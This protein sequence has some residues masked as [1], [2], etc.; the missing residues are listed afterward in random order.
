MP[1]TGPEVA[2]TDFHQNSISS[3]NGPPSAILHR[4]LF[5]P[6]ATLGLQG[7]VGNQAVQR[8]IQN[9]SIQRK[10]TLYDEKGRPYPGKREKDATAEEI[11]DWVFSHIGRKAHE[12]LSVHKEML[13]KL[14]EDKGVDL[15]LSAASRGAEASYKSFLE[16]FEKFREAAEA[17][18]KQGTGQES[19]VRPAKGEKGDKGEYGADIELQP[20]I[21]AVSEGGIT[22][23][24]LALEGALN[25]FVQRAKDGSKAEIKSKF[26]KPL[27]PQL[28]LLLS[29]LTIGLSNFQAEDYPNLLQVIRLQSTFEYDLLTGV[30]RDIDRCLVDL[31][32]AVKIAQVAMADE[33]VGDPE[34]K[35]SLVYDLLADVIQ[36]S[37]HQFLELLFGGEIKRGRH[38]KSS[39]SS[40]ATWPQLESALG[41]LV[42]C[43]PLIRQ[44]HP[45]AVTHFALYDW[46]VRPLIVKILQG[47]VRRFKVESTL[48]CV[49][50]LDPLVPQLSRFA[51]RG[52]ISKVAFDS[53]HSK[54]T[55]FVMGA[56]IYSAKG[57]IRI[58]ET[59]CGLLM[60]DD[61]LTCIGYEAIANDSVPAD[62]ILTGH[63]PQSNE[64]LIV[65]I[66]NIPEGVRREGK[67]YEYLCQRYT[68]KMSTVGKLLESLPHEYKL[69]LMAPIGTK[70][71]ENDIAM[72]EK[73]DRF[74]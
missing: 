30:S 70:L 23:V 24:A 45:I 2:V 41:E 57:Q 14:C 51:E 18:K 33:D 52:R 1:S 17:E 39:T 69:V 49:I 37:R 15:K 11:L 36:M 5:S 71:L 56:T 62:L 25:P 35:A 48:D 67:A 13:Q 73:D 34:S 3:I 68:H 43:V 74:L 28:C 47:T 32:K 55:E 4:L 9:D 65:E 53:I 60:I 27:G 58:L 26:I 59:L 61:Q 8:L 38:G 21:G 66:E 20:T 54:L 44:I 12:D 50:R 19:D 46:D 10:V 31:N 22:G 63:A 40:A 16:K 7:T 64:K 6:A 72:I 42:L 29:Q